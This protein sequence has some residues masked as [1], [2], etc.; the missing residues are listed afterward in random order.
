MLAGTSPFEKGG[1]RGFAFAFDKAKEQIPR[2]SLF[3]TGRSQNEGPGMPG[4]RDVAAAIF[5]QITTR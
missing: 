1:L 5:Y 3:Q 2:S 4:L